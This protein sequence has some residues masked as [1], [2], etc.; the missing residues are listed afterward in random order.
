M[1]EWL[2]DV[3]PSTDLRRWYGHD[4]REIRGVR[5]ALPGRVGHDA[6]PRRRGRGSAA[7]PRGRGRPV[8]LDRDVEHSAAAVLL[9]VLTEPA[10]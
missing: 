10:A 9:E 5:G 7:G 1:D 8:D 3:A 2:K 6:R 4:P